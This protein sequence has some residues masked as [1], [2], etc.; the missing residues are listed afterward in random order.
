MERRE[1]IEGLPTRAMSASEGKRRLIEVVRDLA[2][3]QREFA[4]VAA[5][6]LDEF[7][8]SQARGEWQA[9]VAALARIRQTH[10][11]LATQLPAAMAPAAAGQD[12][13]QESAR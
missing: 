4:G 9:C 11:D 1:P 2:I 6:V 3:E 13:V 12:S 10:P 8:L 5:A 7:M